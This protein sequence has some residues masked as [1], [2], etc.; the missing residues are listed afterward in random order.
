MLAPSTVQDIAF[1]NLR[2]IMTVMSN[3][4]KY[5]NDRTLSIFSYKVYAK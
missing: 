2:M 1:V 4:S 3:I 5:K